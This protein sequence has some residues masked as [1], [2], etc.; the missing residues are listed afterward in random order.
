MLLAIAG[1]AIALLTSACGLYAGP[2]PQL[3]PTPA[4]AN[5]V[6]DAGFESGLG[7][8]QSLGQVGIG[9]EARSGTRSIVLK[10]AGSAPAAVSQT[11]RSKG[12]PEYVSGFYR[13]DGWNAAPDAGS[14]SF[15]IATGG[16]TTAGSGVRFFIAGARTAS[17]GSNSSISNLFISRGA[18][19]VG[20]WTYFAY[21]VGEAVRQRL[22]SATAAG[23]EVTLSLEV[24][25]GSVSF[26]DLYAGTQFDNPNRP[27]QQ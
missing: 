21:P 1:C 4:R 25:G 9:R 6:D 16:G 18:P 3:T 10:S 13:A 5:L 26:D 19:A 27:P 7:S 14:I 15:V 17:R 23:G 12:V 11:L 20:A 24:Q 8:W 22:G 2:E